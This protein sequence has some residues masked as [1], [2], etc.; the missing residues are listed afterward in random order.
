MR[1]DYVAY[2]HKALQKSNNIRTTALELSVGKKPQICTLGF[3]CCC[4]Y[5]QLFFL[6]SS[7]LSVSTQKA[8]EMSCLMTK[9]NKT[10]VRPA[11]TQISLGIPPVWSESSLCAHWVAKDPSFLHV[12]SEDSDQTGG[13][14]RLIWVFAGLTDL[15]GFVM[16]QLKCQPRLSPLVHIHTCPYTSKICLISVRTWY[17]AWKPEVYPKIFKW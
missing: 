17:I 14:A 2:H 13:M 15:V 11:E 5:T 12:D 4:E 7:S 9:L 1:K 16:R 10:T 8:S 6:H 3:S